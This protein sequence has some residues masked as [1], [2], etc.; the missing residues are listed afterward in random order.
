MKY[1]LT[2]NNDEYGIG[3]FEDEYDALEYASKLIKEEYNEDI[4][5]EYDL[6]GYGYRIMYVEEVE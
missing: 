2:V 5:D 6:D 1:I 4:E 3:M